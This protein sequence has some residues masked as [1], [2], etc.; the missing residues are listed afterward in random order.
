MAPHEKPSKYGGEQ[1]GE[2]SPLFGEKANLNG[3]SDPSTPDGE[4]SSKYDK[5]GLLSSR[6]LWT[7][8]VVIVVIVTVI[9]GFVQEEE[10]SELE[11]VGPYKAKEIQKGDDFFSFYDFNEGADNPGSGGINDYVSYERA[12]EIGILNVTSDGSVYMGSAPS[13]ADKSFKRQS[14]RLEGKTR[15]DRGLFVIDLDHMPAGCGAWPAFWLSDDE[16]WPNGGEIDMVEGINYQSKV[17]TALHTAAQCSMFNQFPQKV[18]TGTWEW[19]AGIYNRWSGIPDNKT[20]VETDNCWVSSPHQWTNQGCV[21]VSDQDDTLGVPLNKNGGGVFVMEWDPDNGYIRSWAFT[22]HNT[23]PEN[24]V[25]ALATADDK[26]ES[27]R[28]APDSSLW[29]LPYAYFAIGPGTDCTTNHFKQQRLII[30]LAFCGGVAGNRFY[31]DCPA[32]SKNFRNESIFEPVKSCERYIKTNPDEIT[33]NAYWK[34]RSVHVWER[35]LSQPQNE[36]LGDL[37]RYADD[38]DVDDDDDNTTGTNVTK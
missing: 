4:Y 5:Y 12:K 38:D 24:L 35:S 25:Q 27:K 16:D 34:T 29:G 31:A 7:V 21:T 18:R 37:L 13:G 19:A 36:T 3:V 11:Y 26:D 17:K 1:Q 6:R 10:E 33:E 30:N 9:L 15:F 8:A 32:I 28:V 23:V 14:I 20:L 22:P 2:L